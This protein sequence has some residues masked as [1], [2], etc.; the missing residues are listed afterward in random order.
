[1]DLWEKCVAFH[2]HHCGGL[3]IGYAA[4]LYA[5]E[6]LKVDF[7]DNEQ[8]VCISENDACGVDAIQVGLGCSIGK[9]NLLFH[10]TGKQ[11]FS[12]YNRATNQSVR[13][14]LKPK[15]LGMTREES[16][17]YYQSCEPKD[18]FDVKEATIQLPEKAIFCFT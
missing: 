8:V 17:A 9:G 10:M 18:M 13:L 1:M 4:S 12:F 11:A 7:S 2:G 3:R 14:V 5:M 16:F 6:L 15:P